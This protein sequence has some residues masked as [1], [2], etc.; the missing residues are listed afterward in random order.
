M[1]DACNGKIKIPFR[2]FRVSVL[3]GLTRTYAI[4]QLAARS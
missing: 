2:H 1:A 3:V 4:T